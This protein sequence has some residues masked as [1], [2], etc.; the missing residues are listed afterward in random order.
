MTVETLKTKFDAIQKES[1]DIYSQLKPLFKRLKS[2]SKKCCKLGEKADE[3]KGLYN[4]IPV[5]V[6]AGNEVVDTTRIEPKDNWNMGIIYMLDDFDPLDEYMLC[7]DSVLYNLK[8][9]KF[10]VKKRKT[11]G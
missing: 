5:K 3:D 10:Y 1:N 8:H 6:Q 9:T 2:L 4:N 7:I 11:G